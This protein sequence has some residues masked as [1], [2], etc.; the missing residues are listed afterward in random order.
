[1]L[2]G[3]EA[4]VNGREVPLG[5][6]EESLLRFLRES[7]GLKGAKPGCGEGACGACTVL[8][9]GRPV[10]AC[11][12]PLRAV[13]GAAVL[14]VEGLAENGLLHPVQE[15]FVEVGAFQCGYCTPGMLMSTVALL[16]H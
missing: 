12:T 4:T 6:A 2:P 11:V 1:M 16:R 7:L 5:E 8:V 14:T 3:V 10:R 13:A 9:E 15:A